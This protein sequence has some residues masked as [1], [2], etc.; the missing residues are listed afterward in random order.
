MHLYDVS[1]L[2]KESEWRTKIRRP[3]E[4]HERQKRLASPKAM[5]R[6][7][8]PG[9]PTRTMD[10]AAS[11]GKLHHPSLNKDPRMREFKLT[12]SGSKELHNKIWTRS[13]KQIFDF[14]R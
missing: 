13:L 7:P 8:L 2:K 14:Y 6:S 12:N 10:R 5:M 1:T 3:W 9:H 4:A 11:K